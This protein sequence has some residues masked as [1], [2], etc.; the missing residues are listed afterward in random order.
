MAA[1][2]KYIPKHWQFIES[3]A[4]KDVLTLYGGSA[5]GKTYSVLQY[6]IRN[7]LSQE[8]YE[9]IL[10]R[11]YR[12]TLK[13]TLLKD[14]VSILK[15]VGVWELCE[16]NKSE[17]V[18][19]YGPNHLYFIP[20]IEPERIKGIDVD[21]IYVDEVTEVEEDIFQQLLL[22]FG[23]SKAHKHAQLIT[24]FNPVS[25]EHWCYRELVQAEYPERAC[26]HSTHLDNPFLSEQFRQRLLG[27]RD[28]D[29][30][31]FRV[32][33]LGEPGK[34]TGL[35]YP[36]NWEVV[37]IK[38]EEFDA[39]GI[40]WGYTHP[41]VCVGCKQTGERE[42]TFRQLYYESGKLVD[43]DFMPW[44][45]RFKGI[46]KLNRTPIYP[47][48]ANPAYNQ[49]L[50]NAGYTVGK[51]NKDVIPGINFLKGY[52]LRFTSDSPDLIKEIRTYSWRVD[53]E[54][55]EMDEPVKE[56]DD[57]MDACRYAAASHFMI[58]KRRITKPIFLAGG[59]H[60]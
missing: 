29:E 33:C 42:F 44:L 38:L 9:A 41:L 56:F 43:A 18:I 30:N 46:Y 31:F 51:T 36:A 4:D 3:H 5:S 47:D 24:S 8:S 2:V 54:G 45:E 57:G 34:A 48:T 14:V 22:R 52:K 39:I 50:L 27:L 20:L 19:S 49:M 17:L 35:V 53:K 58:K 60:V 32:Y 13:L 23:R 15:S 11:K 25:A 16:F 59:G 21:C 7:F 37:D 10:C 28:V 1:R 12:P 40:D 26:D 6:I 55:N